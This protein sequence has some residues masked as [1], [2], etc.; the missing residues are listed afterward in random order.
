MPSILAISNENKTKSQ[1]NCT[2]SV[3]LRGRSLVANDLE[4]GRV[5][6]SSTL[7]FDTRVNAKRNTGHAS[8]S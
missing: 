5:R 3:K 1:V 7:K 2:E 4:A 8:R 6:S